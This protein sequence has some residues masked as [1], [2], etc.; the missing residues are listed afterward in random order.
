MQDDEIPPIAHPRVT[1]VIAV[2]ANLYSTRSHE[3]IDMMIHFI[4]DNK[5]RSCRYSAIL[6][7]NEQSNLWSYFIRIEKPIDID[8]DGILDPMIHLMRSY[9][10]EFI[11]GYYNFRTSELPQ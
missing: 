11:D 10:D 9:D 4:C 6:G 8:H 1:G 5:G 2:D 7:T 3:R